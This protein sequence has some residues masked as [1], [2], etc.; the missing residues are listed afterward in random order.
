MEDVPV[1]LL[2]P[3][4]M[5][6]LE[7]YLN[8]SNVF[9]ESAVQEF[10]DELW[11][12]MSFFDFETS[13]MV[14]VPLFDGTRPYQQVPFQY[15]L[16]VQEKAGAELKHYEY[17]AQAGT[18]PRKELIEKLLSDIPENSCVLAYNMGFEIGIL[19]DLKGWF[20]EYEE[21]IDHMIAN[22]RDLMVPFRSKAVYHWQM[23]GSY[24]L[25]KVLPALVPELN[26]EDMEVSDGAMASDSWLKMKTMENPEEIEKSRKALLEYCCLDTLAMV[27]IL[28]KIKSSL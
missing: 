27:K 4:Q 15:S 7:G 28:E 9:N 8:K 16:H 18:D 22:M 23:E 13:Y 2:S 5:I 10:L 12:P 20:P 19:S 17:L 3:A 11:Y 25:K 6:Q 1:N 26:Y 24:S 21:K 14:P